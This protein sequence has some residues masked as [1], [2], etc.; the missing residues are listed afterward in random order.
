MR[1]F[2]SAGIF[3]LVQTA[4]ALGQQAVVAVVRPTIAEKEPGAQTRGYGMYREAVTQK[5]ERCGV[6]FDLVTDEQIIAGKLAAYKLAVFPFNSVSRKE[7]IGRILEYVEGGGKLMWFYG[8]PRP[9]G[10]TLG[11]GKCGYR[12]VAYAGEFHTMKFA[13][14]PPG[15]PAEV[16]QES[17]N[18]R[19]VEELLPG[20]RAI[21][22]WH[23]KDGK[24]TNVPAVI[25]SPNSVYVSHVFW[26]D[27]DAAQ[28]ARLLLA[29][30]CHFIPGKW[31][32]IVEGV[33]AK[34]APAAGFD[35][36]E[37]LHKAA[38]KPTARQWAEKAIDQ[39]NRAREALAAGQFGKALDIAEAVQKSTQKAAAATFPSRPYELRGAW[40]HPNDATDYSAVADRVRDENGK[41]HEVRDAPR[42]VDS[43]F[44]S[45]S[46]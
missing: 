33:L 6:P 16:R 35:S 29:T 34:A 12:G 2:T 20:S 37:Q 7:E 26:R 8:F 1:R 19:I 36:L 9:L 43:H 18:C 38:G 5:L 32:G 23:D 28:Q 4:C 27:A 46:T 21:A 45:S 17:P 14:T 15:F 30:I 31:N 10:E 42:L 24:T 39:A 22:V 41:H 25:L 11:I 13:G 3:V 40:V 44:S